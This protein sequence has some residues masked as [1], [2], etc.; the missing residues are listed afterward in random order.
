MIFYIKFSDK[1]DILI[2]KT[3]G[4][5]SGDAFMVMA[6]GILR[7]PQWSKGKSVVFDHRDLNFEGVALEDLEKI[8][9][10]HQRHDD[11]IGPGKSAIVVGPGRAVAWEK[12]WAQ[13]KKIQPANTVKIFE[14]FQA[15]VEWAKE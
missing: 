2:V 1:H 10:F 4:S 3:S 8:R 5:M 9:S 12:L 11:K 15:A 14:D 6:A 7:H 13:G